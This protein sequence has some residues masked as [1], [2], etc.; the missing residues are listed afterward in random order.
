MDDG[1]ASGER[2]CGAACWSADDEAVG[3]GGGEGAFFVFRPERETEVSEVRGGAAVEEDL[4]E[5][6]E[7]GWGEGLAGFVGDGD[8]ESVS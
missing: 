1:A 2:V 5:G 6:V 7:M 3:Y 4:V 8:A